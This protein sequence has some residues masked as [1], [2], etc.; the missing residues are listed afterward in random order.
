M[1]PILI[2]IMDDVMSTP[3]IVSE[4][5]NDGPDE[6]DNRER[7]RARRSRH[8][9]HLDVSSNESDWTEKS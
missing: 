7:A 4:L 1:R 3:V 8:W 9:K 5:M 2:F 6:W